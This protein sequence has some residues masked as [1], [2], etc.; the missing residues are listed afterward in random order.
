MY[1]S[2]VWF[3]FDLIVTMPWFFPLPEGAKPAQ[4]FEPGLCPG[5]KISCKAWAI[6]KRPANPKSPCTPLTCFVRAVVLL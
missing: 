4:Q 6:N 3:C 1:T 5:A 2:E